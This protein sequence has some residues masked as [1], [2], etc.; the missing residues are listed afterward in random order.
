MNGWPALA[1]ANALV[2]VGTLPLLPF[3]YLAYIYNASSYFRCM[4]S[5]S[6]SRT[7]GRSRRQLSPLLSQR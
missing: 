3:R 2:L 5:S 7:Y 4:E 6:Y 1:A